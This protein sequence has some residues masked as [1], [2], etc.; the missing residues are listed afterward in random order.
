M[1]NWGDIAV[2]QVHSAVLAGMKQAG[3][4]KP[5]DQFAMHHLVF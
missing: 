1:N 4:G 2:L 3:R 5:M